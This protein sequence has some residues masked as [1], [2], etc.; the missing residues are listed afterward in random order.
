MVTTDLAHSGGSPVQAS[1]LG[2][3]RIA[4]GDLRIERQLSARSL[5]VCAML[6]GHPHEALSRDELAFTLW[7][8]FE[9]EAR[10]ALRREFFATHPIL[11]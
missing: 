6:P 7:P 10:A 11:R 1:F 9:R 3:T 5:L 8:D 2:H 4:C